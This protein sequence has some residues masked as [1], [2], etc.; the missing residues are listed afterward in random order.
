[1]HE[2]LCTF[3]ADGRRDFSRVLESRRV[4]VPLD[5]GDEATDDAGTD[6]AASDEQR[7]RTEAV[8]AANWDLRVAKGSFTF[9]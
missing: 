4:E 7:R 3:A 6:G 5:L 1:L 2:P 9:I 8:T